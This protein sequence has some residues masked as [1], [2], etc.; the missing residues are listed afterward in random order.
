GS[1]AF[2][3]P[4]TPSVG[5]APQDLRPLSK[6]D[7]KTQKKLGRLEEKIRKDEVKQFGDKKGFLKS[8]LGPKTAK[9]LFNI[10]RNPIGFLTGALKSLPILGGI[11]AAKEMAEFV[12]QELV[13]LDAFFKAFIDIIDNRTNKFRDLE[14]QARIAAGLQQDIITTA[15]GGVDPRQSYNTFNVFEQNQIEIEEKYTLQN[16]SG[17]D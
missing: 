5:G 10:G 12:I 1:G 14:T 3:G 16:T 4:N 13:K 15:D 17:V 2:S 11:L 8:I 6:Q 7:Q 9:N